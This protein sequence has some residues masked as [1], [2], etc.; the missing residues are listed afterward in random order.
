MKEDFTTSEVEELDTISLLLL[1]ICKADELDSS[2]YVLIF[3]LSETA[4]I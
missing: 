4:T 1:D 3:E 2:A